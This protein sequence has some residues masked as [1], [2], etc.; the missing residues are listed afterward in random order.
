MNA[1]NQT[2]D[3]ELLACEACLDEI[4]ADE[5][6][7]RKLSIMLFTTMDW[8]V[9]PGGSNNL[10]ITIPEH[11][12]AHTNKAGIVGLVYVATLLVSEV[13]KL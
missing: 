11:L 9:T 4:P 3:M 6:K 10:A 1:D 7:T 12:V 5:A 2:V 8:N 13:I